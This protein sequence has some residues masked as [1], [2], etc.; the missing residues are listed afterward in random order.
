MGC[1]I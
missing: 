1:S